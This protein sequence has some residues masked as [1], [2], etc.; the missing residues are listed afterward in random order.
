M[1]YTDRKREIKRLGV[2]INWGP[3]IRDKGRANKEASTQDGKEQEVALMGKPV[4]FFNHSWV[5]SSYLGCTVE[6]ALPMCR[7]HNFLAS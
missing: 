6:L 2:K 3:A 5:I 4:Q 1:K 7:S